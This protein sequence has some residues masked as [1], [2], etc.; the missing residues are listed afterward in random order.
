MASSGG[1]FIQHGMRTT[2]E[3]VGLSAFIS[4]P[5]N[6]SC[7]AGDPSSSAVVVKPAKSPRRRD[8]GVRLPEISPRS[9]GSEPAVTSS[10]RAREDMRRRLQLR[11]NRARLA[12]VLEG[13][14]NERMLRIDRQQLTDALRKMDIEPNRDHIEELFRAFDVIESGRIDVR[15]LHDALWWGK[16]DPRGA[17]A[18]RLLASAQSYRDATLAEEARSPRQPT[19]S[20]R[21]AMFVEPPQASPG[22]A[23]PAPPR[24]T[25]QLR[26]PDAKA[27]QLFRQKSAAVLCDAAD[28]VDP[29][30]VERAAAARRVEQLCE[31]AVR[32]NGRLMEALTSYDL[33][34]DSVVAPSDLHLALRSVGLRPSERDSEALYWSWALPGE[35]S[36]KLVTVRRVL[37]TDG[38][39]RAPPKPKPRPS[40]RLV[41]QAQEADQAAMAKR[42]KKELRKSV[43]HNI[44]DG[45]NVHSACTHESPCRQPPASLVL[46]VALGCYTLA[47]ARPSVEPLRRAHPAP[48]PDP[49]PAPAPHRHRRSN[50]SRGWGRSRTT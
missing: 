18:L 31:A 26:R 43:V 47:R 33:R 22:R 12:V 8:S 41:Q 46:G 48:D 17:A 30:E 40:P 2:C 27:L 10:A 50:S 3:P 34:A 25:Q 15:V 36:L 20:E 5:G 37:Q 42:I 6:C 44:R 14:A 21:I 39:K 24:E 45:E 7:T 13:L 1:T 32:N 23:R 28:A 49:D 38:G 9:A 35:E 19:A 16:R 11:T 4:A 29:R